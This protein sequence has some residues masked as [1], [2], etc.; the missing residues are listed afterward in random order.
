MNME[1]R[2]AAYASER[3]LDRSIAVNAFVRSVYNWMAI[4]LALTGGVAYYTASTPA[5]IQMIVG[6]PIVFFGL[7]IAEL[8][9][10]GY[11]S[12]RIYKMEAGT[13]T[14]LFL[15][16]SVLNGLTLS[17]L[18][19][20]Y[21]QSS[22]SSAFFVCAGTF[23]A[24][25]VYGY[26]TKKDLTSMGSFMFMGLI[27][28]IIAS[29]VN[30]FLKSGPVEMAISYLGVVI[31]VGLTAYDTQKIKNMAATMPVDVGAGAMRKGALMGALALYLDFVN[32]FIMLLRIMGR[33][34]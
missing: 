26:T 9:V 11:F 28:I 14:G 12:A 2:Y 25:S 27:G 18:L 17:I 20:A 10:V 29:V 24:V 7:I 30:M 13:A 22:V 3:A 19:L 33:R 15:G 21:T 1:E 8:V 4:G 16:Y 23:A 5:L 32:L 31:F 6:N 34:R